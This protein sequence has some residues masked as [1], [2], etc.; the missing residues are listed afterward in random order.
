[1]V[2]DLVTQVAGLR[3]DTMVYL[4]NI[5]MNISRL[6]AVMGEMA[7]NQRYYMTWRMEESRS[8]GSSRVSADYSVPEDS[9]LWHEFQEWRQSV[10]RITQEE[11]EE[12]AKNVGEGE[13]EESGE[14]DGGDG[15]D[16]VTGKVSCSRVHGSER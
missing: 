15:E 9:P 16:E 2:E 1:M 7:D 10:G 11:F 13:A 6:T 8:E 12:T 14:G 5:A 4:E 3:E